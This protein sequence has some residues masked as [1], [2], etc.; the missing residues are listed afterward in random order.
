MRVL[1]VI[2]HPN[3]ASFTQA[4]ASHFAKGAQAGGHEVDLA[5][6]HA[7]GFNPTWSMA[8]QNQ[9]KRPPADIIPEQKRIE[10]CDALCLAFPLYWYGMPAMTKGWIDRVWTYGWA[11]DQVGD[12]HKSL[13]R[14]RIGV[15]LIPAGG[16]PDNWAP[17]GFEAAMRTQ[18]ETGI[19]GYFGLTDKRV[20]FLNG[21]EGSA[22]RREGLLQ[23]AY[24]VGLTLS[25]AEPQLDAVAHGWSRDT[26]KER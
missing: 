16:N 4:V 13:L 23:R 25:D 7:E 19:M 3:P 22:P 20:H 10:R 1:I 17:Y 6:L 15:M 12:P 5:D 11:Y 26:G 8:D 2:D 24:Q 14:D 21:S 9:G 18:L